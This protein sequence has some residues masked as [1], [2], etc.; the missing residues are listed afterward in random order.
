M[1]VAGDLHRRLAALLSHLTLVIS[2]TDRGE[3]SIV[4]L[5]RLLVCVLEQLHFTAHTT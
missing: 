1:Q 3:L 2:T 4:E 5:G